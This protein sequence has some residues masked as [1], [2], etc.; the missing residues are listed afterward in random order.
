MPLPAKQDPGEEGTFKRGKDGAR[1]IIGNSARGGGLTLK[2]RKSSGVQASFVRQ[3]DGGLGRR[4]SAAKRNLEKHADTKGKKRTHSKK[5]RQKKKTP[6][7]KWRLE[8]AKKV[9]QKLQ[10][11]QQPEAEGEPV[12]GKEV[13][14]V[15]DARVEQDRLK[16]GCSGKNNHSKQENKRGGN[17]KPGLKRPGGGVELPS[18]FDGV[19]KSRTSDFPY[20]QEERKGEKRTK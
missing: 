4:G 15:R 3:L 2:E 9:N 20:G 12:L 6:R 7:H 5:P 19:G 13:T 16:K 18:V 8:G 17:G 10:K 14:R 1:F 11:L